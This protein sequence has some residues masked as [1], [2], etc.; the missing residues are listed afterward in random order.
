VR[1]GSP[2]GGAGGLALGVARGQGE[3]RHL[4]SG[5]LRPGSEPAAGSCASV[6]FCFV[7]KWSKR[8]Q[9]LWSQSR[10]LRP[11]RRLSSLQGGEAPCEVPQLELSGTQLQKKAGWLSREGA[12]SP[13]GAGFAQNKAGETL[14]GRT[15]RHTNEL[16]RR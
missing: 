8:W 3:E 7:F 6:L 4:A 11:G 16:Q 14:G 15:W 9:K 2:S 5:G 10:Q 13:A 12:A 1:R